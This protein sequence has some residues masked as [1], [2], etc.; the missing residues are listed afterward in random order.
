MPIQMGDEVE[1]EYELMDS[2]GERIESSSDDDGGPIRIKLGEGDLPEKL[3]AELVGKSAGDEFSLALEPA[4]AFGPYDPENLVSVP[5][6]EVPED[7]ELEP[8]DWVPLALED[9]ETGEG[10]DIEAR[11]VEVNPDGFVLDLNHPLAQE[12][13]TFKMKVIGT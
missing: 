1:L 9:E 8:G 11:V 7:I 13:V 10:D 2:T 4:D 3:E 6:E 5:R 12:T